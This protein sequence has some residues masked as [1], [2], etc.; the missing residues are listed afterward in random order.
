M[1]GIQFEYTT[2]ADD[3]NARGRVLFDFKTSKMEGDLQQDEQDGMFRFE[4]MASTFGNVDFD[5]DI[6]EPGAFTASLGE[7]GS[8]PRDHRPPDAGAVQP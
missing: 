2:K 8:A 1:D 3:D 5:G 4:G 7:A 6:I